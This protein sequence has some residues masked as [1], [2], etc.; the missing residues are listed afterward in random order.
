MYL[1][2]ERVLY[3]AAETYGRPFLDVIQN[4]FQIRVQLLNRVRVAGMERHRDHRA[5]LIQIDRDHAS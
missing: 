3:I 5:D 1:I 2:L 4:I